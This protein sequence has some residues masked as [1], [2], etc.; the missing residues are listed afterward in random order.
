MKLSTRSRDRLLFG[1]AE[2][3]DNNGI[4]ACG[5]QSDTGS[6]PFFQRPVDIEP[7]SIRIGDL[8]CDGRTDGRRG[9]QRSLQICAYLPPEGDC[10]QYNHNHKGSTSITACKQSVNSRYTL[11]ISSLRVCEAAVYQSQCCFSSHVLAKNL[12]L[13][14][15]IFYIYSFS[16]SKQVQIFHTFKW[17]SALSRHYG[18]TRE[19][20]LISGPTQRQSRDSKDRQ[21]VCTCKLTF[22]LTFIAWRSINKFPIVDQVCSQL[23]TSSYC[24]YAKDSKSRK[25]LIRGLTDLYSNSFLL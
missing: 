21:L 22:N 19:L 18:G 4:S 12:Q 8:H 13:L 24:I 25:V 15:F 3:A 9:E 17:N 2:A 1:S 7:A 10:A 20:G 16:F 11:L 5:A 14:I 23:K 6:K